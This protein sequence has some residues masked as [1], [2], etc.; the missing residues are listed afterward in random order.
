M[1]PL[2]TNGT[3]VPTPAAADAEFDPDQLPTS[4]WSAYL[5]DAATP[6]GVSDLIS[7]F[8][9]QNALTPAAEQT[10]RQLPPDLT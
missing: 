7:A 9:L 6:I 2:P 4:A 5:Q 10:L 3:A 8:M 1:V